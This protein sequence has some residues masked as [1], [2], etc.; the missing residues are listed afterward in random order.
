MEVIG[1]IIKKNNDLGY[2][3]VAVKGSEDIF[4]SPKT[5]YISTNFESL[6]IGDKVKIEVTETDRGLFANTLSMVLRKEK[7]SAI[8]L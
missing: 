3:F 8:D 5:G 7:T 2:G 6:N 4:F 1:Q